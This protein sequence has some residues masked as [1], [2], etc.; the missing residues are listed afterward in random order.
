[1]SLRNIL[2]FGCRE[3]NN[4]E[5]KDGDQL[6]E[7]THSDSDAQLSKERVPLQ[8]LCED[9]DCAEDQ[10][11]EREWQGVDDSSE[12]LGKWSA[13]VY[14]KEGKKRKRKG[15]LRERTVVPLGYPGVSLL[16]CFPPNEDKVQMKRR[17]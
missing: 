4:Q 2:E 10:S 5:D 13:S 7:E 3:T 9:R 12:K 15:R 11:D 17:T 16:P 1:M 6:R 8:L 14:G